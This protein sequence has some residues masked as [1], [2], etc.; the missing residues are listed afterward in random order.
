MTIGSRFPLLT[1]Q[2]PDE[3]IVRER[4]LRNRAQGLPG[5]WVMPDYQELSGEPSRGCGS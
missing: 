2:V 3:A 4:C 1:L 5:C